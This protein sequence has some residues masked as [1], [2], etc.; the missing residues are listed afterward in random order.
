M[1]IYENRILPTIINLAC[2]SPEIMKLRQQVV[3]LCTGTVL[4]V[5]AGSGINFSLYDPQLV[6]RVL[7][8]EPSTGMRRKA[9][10]KNVIQA[11]VPVEWLEL[12]GEQIPLADHSVDT[13]LLT[14]TL[15]SIA[16][17]Q[18]ALRQMRRVLRPG[19]QLLFCEHGRAEDVRVQRWQDRLNPLWKLLAGGCHLNRPI[20]QNICDGGFEIV[21]ETSQYLPGSPKFAGF[22]CYG[23][24][25]ID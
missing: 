25:V 11:R 5:G 24:A 18:A 19:G 17:H 9:R 12:P 8:L 16:D 23:R 20:K 13:I 21:E 7:A 3:P 6:D 14:F 4:E 22:V 15:C 2:S 1:G 10:S